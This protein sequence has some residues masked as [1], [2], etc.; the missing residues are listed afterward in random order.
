MR[1]ALKFAY[2]GKNFYG[3]ARQ[4]DLRT[5]EGELI[6]ILTGKNIIITPS[7]SIFRSS[8]RTDKGVSALCNVIAFNTKCSFEDIGSVLIDGYEDLLIYGIAEV[9][10]DFNPRYAKSRH[11]RYHLKD[12]GYDL[13]RIIA[14]SSSFIGEH[15]FSNFAKIESFRNPVRKIDQILITK[16]QNFIIVDFFA[17]TFL[18]NQI[19][20]IISALQKIGENKIDNKAILEALTNVEKNIDFG[21]AKADPLMLMDITFDFDFITDEK[22]NEKLKNFN[23]EL[24]DQIKQS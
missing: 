15:N 7:E 20:R 19:R 18:W 17:Q 4:P 1:V 22:Q 24:T 5:V 23:F 16:D 3:Y 11:Y 8:S 6:K 2:N 9:E 13:E 21:L 14:A 10:S 12:N